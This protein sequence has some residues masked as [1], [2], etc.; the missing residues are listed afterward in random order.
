MANLSFIDRV[1]F[2][3]WWYLIYPIFPAFRDSLIWLHIIHHVGRQ[4]WH[5][6][7]LAPGRTRKGLAEHLIK[8]GF[9]IHFIAWVDQ[10]QVLGIRKRVGFEYQYH[11]RVFKDGELRG[12]YEETPESHP[13]GHLE[14]E[15]FKPRTEEFKEFLEDWIV[16]QPT[17]SGNTSAQIAPPT[18]RDLPS[19][20]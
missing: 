9:R 5:I 12:H 7:W 17:H 13:F 3:V 14:E 2:Y 4:P 18:S 6:G 19:N 10:G 15:M 16:D 1:K 8:Y 20:G 11:L